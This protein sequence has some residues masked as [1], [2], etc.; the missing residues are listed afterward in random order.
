MLEGA[1]LV[2]PGWDEVTTALVDPEVGLCSRS[3]RFTQADVVEHICAISGGRLSAEEVTA[4]SDRFLA[5]DLVVRL[6]PDTGEGRRRP[7]QWSTAAHRALEDRTLALA[8][9]LSR[10]EVPALHND[11]L[12]A[13]LAGEPGL[14]E[15][16]V[17]AVRVLA[18]DGCSLRAVLAPAGYGKTTMLHAAARAA[19]ADGRPVVAVAT[20]A[21]AVAELSGAGLDARTIARLRVDLANGPL[22]VGSIVVLDEISQTPTHEVE[23]VLA[24]VDACPGGSIWVLGDPRQSQP[25]G[26]G[27]MADHVERLAAGSAI[28]AARLTVN[29][30]QLDP[31]DREALDLLRQGDAAGSQQLRGEHGWEHEHASPAAAREAMAQ[32]VCDDIGRYGP[33][34]VAALVVSHSD[35]E[36]LADRLRARLAATGTLTGAGPGWPGVDGRP[37]VPGRGQGAAPRPLRPLG[38]PARQRHHRHGHR[39]RQRRPR[40]PP[41]RRRAGSGRC[42]RLRTGGSQGRLAQRLARLGPYRRRGTRRHLGGLPPARQLGPRRLSGLHRPVPLPPADPHLEH[43]PG[44]SSTTAGALPTSAEAPSRSPPR[45]AVSPTHPGGAQ[46]PLRPR[47]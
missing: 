28:P 22:A 17:A 20:T 47:P 31:V 1:C 2:P 29:R 33:A 46:R 15:D 45:S 11:A 42:R 3:A 19:A 21:K 40:R 39:R 26:A 14:G 18:A 43:H 36:D 10:R 5:S 12:E 24:A 30:R 37:G 44:R 23:A 41:R 25:V 8:E 4:L 13:V 6:T 34:E 27:G 32:A 9:T 38:Q 35:A 7:P 16:Q